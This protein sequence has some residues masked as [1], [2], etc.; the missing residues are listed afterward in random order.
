MALRSL[1]VFL[2]MLA[3]AAAPAFATTDPGFDRLERSLRLNPIQQQQFDVAVRATHRAMITI[4]MGALQFK[5]RLGLE[6]LKDR[7]D[8]KA[9][10]LAQDELVDLA[11]P[12]VRA[13]KDE[14]L[15]FYSLL[16]DEQLGAARGYLEERLRKL[17]ELAEHLIQR[18]GEETRA[19]G[20]REPL[21]R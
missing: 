16:D 13:A 1:L 10:E 19:Q 12:Q 14:W 2:V 6:L 17:E 4:G 11:R 3:S 7:P 18:L 5:S 20:R 8:P 21:Q 9:L 15:R